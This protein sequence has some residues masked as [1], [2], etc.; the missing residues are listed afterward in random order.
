MK[1]RPPFNC[2][3][4]VY[5]EVGIKSEEQYIDP[6]SLG[7]LLKYFDQVED[8]KTATVLAVIAY[9]PKKPYVAHIALISE[10]K[11]KITHRKIGQHISTEDLKSGLEE[12]LDSEVDF[13]RLIY[14]KPKNRNQHFI[15]KLLKL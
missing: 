10:D 4:F 11:L 13:R 9:S 5:K 12:Y 2:V 6:P 8:I 1:E 7:K 14:L 15:L 3:G